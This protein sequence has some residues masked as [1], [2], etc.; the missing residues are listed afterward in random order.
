MELELKHAA[1]AEKAFITPVQPALVVAMAAHN[2]VIQQASVLIAKEVIIQL[3]T[4]LFVRRTANKEDVLNVMKV[5]ILSAMKL[6]QV[7]L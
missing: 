2:A 3:L 4:L 6:K 5:T 7:L 1:H